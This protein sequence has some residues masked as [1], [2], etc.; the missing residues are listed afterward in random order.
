MILTQNVSKQTRRFQ[1]LMVILSFKFCSPRDPSRFSGR[2]GEGVCSR[3]VLT[4]V[5]SGYS[6]GSAVWRD[7]G[8]GR[9][10]RGVGGERGLQ[11]MTNK[12]HIHKG[13]GRS[14]LESNGPF[15]SSSLTRN[16]STLKQRAQ[17]ADFGYV[18]S[19][20]LS[21]LCDSSPLSW[22]LSW[23]LSWHQAPSRFT[24]VAQSL[25]V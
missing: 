5:P 22:L 10:L 16:S 4:S 13:R 8:K 9:G 25:P 24:V 21:A 23:L 12:W 1:S 15:T 14:N 2:R 3:R 19:A 17:E 20:S 11:K 18:H 7:R 6:R